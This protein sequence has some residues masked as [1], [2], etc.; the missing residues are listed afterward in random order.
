MQMTARLLGGLKSTAASAKLLQRMN[1]ESIDRDGDGIIG[2]K[3]ASTVKVLSEAY[4]RVDIDNDG[5]ISKKT[6]QR[7]NAAA[8]RRYMTVGVRPTRSPGYR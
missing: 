1:F 8:N 3:E 4:D 6:T 5:L 2:P 7:R